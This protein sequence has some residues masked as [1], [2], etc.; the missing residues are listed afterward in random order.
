[1]SL[2]DL[3]LEDIN[4]EGKNI[5][6]IKRQPQNTSKEGFLPFHFSLI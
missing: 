1:M 4:A 2:Q 5:M 6:V 3:L